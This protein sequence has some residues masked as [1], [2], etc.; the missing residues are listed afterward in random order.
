MPSSAAAGTGWR[1]VW[2]GVSLTAYAIVAVAIMLASCMQASIGFG[3]GMLA[4]PIVAIVDPKLIPGTLIMLADSERTRECVLGLRAGAGDV[5]TRPV[6]VVELCARIEACLRRRPVPHVPAGPTLR[7]GDVEVDLCDARV[8]KAG[9]MVAPD[10]TAA[11]RRQA[12]SRQT[13]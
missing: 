2:L 5:L 10:P 9:R 7:F 1:G 3:M 13:R 8:A 11:S 4:A 6:Q 12:P